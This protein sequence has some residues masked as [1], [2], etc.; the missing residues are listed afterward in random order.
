LEVAFQGTFIRFYI[1]K[2]RVQTCRDVAREKEVPVQVSASKYSNVKT[3]SCKTFGLWRR[4]GFL[5]SDKR[6]GLQKA[7]LVK[8]ELLLKTRHFPLVYSVYLF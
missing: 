1:R 7:E 3:L 4:C 6:E 5:V 2:V 8:G